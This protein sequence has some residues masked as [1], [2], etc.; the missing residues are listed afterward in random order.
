[1]TDTQKDTVS[2]SRERFAAWAERLELA[3][4]GFPG[5]V[6]F[7][8]ELRA[9]LAQPAEQQDEP[10]AWLDLEKLKPGGMAY[11]TAMKVNHR[12]VPLYR[13]PAAQAV[14]TEDQE[15]ASFVE[16]ANSEYG[17]TDGYELNLKNVD[18]V[19]NRKGWMARANL[20]TGTAQAV[21]LPK[22]MPTGN[23][24]VPH[25]DLPPGVREGWNPCLD[26]VAKLNGIE[27]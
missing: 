6:P 5:S 25:H 3:D 2:V 9:I 15:Q 11:A 8:P 22:R 14:K 26:A 23:I 10:V 19:Q 16:W 4:S 7:L 24:T 20:E 12:Q 21:K 13:R 18:L 17:I 1:M 27:P